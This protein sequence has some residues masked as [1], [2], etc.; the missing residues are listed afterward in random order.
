MAPV[1]Q[2]ASAANWCWPLFAVP[3][4]T[5]F[6]LSLWGRMVSD[7]PV[8]YRRLVGG[9]NRR[10]AQ[11]NKDLVAQTLVC[12]SVGPMIVVCH[13]FFVGQGFQPADRASSRS[14]RRSRRVMSK[15]STSAKRGSFRS[16]QVRRGAQSRLCRLG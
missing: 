3:C 8:G 2:R 5:D 7:A 9:Q 4:V 12:D 14:G 1:T 10:D 11:R 16:V 13:H 15:P 6:S